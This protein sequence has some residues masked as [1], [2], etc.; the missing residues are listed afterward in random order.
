MGTWNQKKCC[1]ETYFCC[2]T[3]KKNGDISVEQ[4]TQEI[5]GI[6]WCFTYIRTSTHQIPLN[7]MK[8]PPP[9]LTQTS[10]LHSTVF[11]TQEWGF[12]AKTPGGLE[13]LQ[14]DDL[15]GNYWTW[16]F[17]VDLPIKNGD[18][19]KLNGNWILPA[20]SVYVQSFLNLHVINPGGRIGKVHLKVWKW[21][22][23]HDLDLNIC[24]G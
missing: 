15:S 16:P 9:V 7:P 1:V 4:E 18:F 6:L 23:F 20:A 8:L 19:W 24:V 22:N 2:V 3:I 13:D 21:G 10:T 14:I 17:I 11:W 5:I 12:A